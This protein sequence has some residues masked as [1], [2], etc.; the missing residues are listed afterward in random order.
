MNMKKQILISVALTF[1]CALS[2]FA[3]PD[4]KALGEYPP[5]EGSPLA[6]F[7]KFANACEVRD[8]ELMKQY[9]GSGYTYIIENNPAY[10]NHLHERFGTID[11]DRSVEYH[12]FEEE[13]GKIRLKLLH[14]EKGVEERQYMDVT[15]VK[16]SG[17]WEVDG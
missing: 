1:L 3:A 5:E 11:F 17:A 6:I 13:A 4:Y 8:V 14:F 12:I 10:V 15:I 16:K 9:G 2:S 7:L